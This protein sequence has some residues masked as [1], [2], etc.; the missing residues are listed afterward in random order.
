MLS[1]YYFSYDENSQILFDGIINGCGIPDLSIILYASAEE[2]IKRIFLRDRN[3]SD[4]A[5]KRVYENGY[6][7][8]F[9]AIKRYGLNYLVVNTDKLNQHET[10]YICEKIIELFTKNIL[11]LKEMQEIFSIDKMYNQEMMDSFE[12]MN[13]IESCSINNM[14]KL[15]K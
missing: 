1:T 4:L 7:K 12:I 3:D 11:D 9:E 8:F 13:F 2:R 14:L 15:K 5:K 6:E 10:I